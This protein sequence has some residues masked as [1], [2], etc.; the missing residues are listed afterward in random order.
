[1]AIAMS[2]EHRKKIAAAGTEYQRVRV[3]ALIRQKQEP[4][5]DA[6]TM[7]R[8]MARSSHISKPEKPFSEIDPKAS[9]TTNRKKL[10][11]RSAPLITALET[12]RDKVS[13][14]KI[15]EVQDQIDSLIRTRDATIKVCLLAATHRGGTK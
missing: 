7:F 5:V 6:M 8:N 12:L 1:M 10:I 2:E 13:A 11:L 14:D 15:Q 3:R 4:P 9:F